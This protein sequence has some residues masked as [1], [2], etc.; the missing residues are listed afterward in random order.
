MQ[1]CFSWARRT[2]RR[3]AWRGAHRGRGPGWYGRAGARHHRGAKMP[4]S[5]AV[6][7]ASELVYRPLEKKRGLLA[8]RVHRGR[9]AGPHK[10]ICLTQ[11]GPDDPYTEITAV[12]TIA[13]PPNARN[14]L[15]PARGSSMCTIYHT[16]EHTMTRH[17]TR[18]AAVVSAANLAGRPQARVR[19][20]RP[21]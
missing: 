5:A 1:Q 18:S 21:V 9:L 7:V 13:R 15:S 6:A 11:V 20:P 10:P 2:S 3:L 12:L 17:L 8:P 16:Y 14:T 4:T 19:E